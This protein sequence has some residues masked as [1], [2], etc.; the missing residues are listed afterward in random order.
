MATGYECGKRK[1]AAMSGIGYYYMHCYY[2]DLAHTISHT[3]LF[4]KK[5]PMHEL[6]VLFLPPTLI[7]STGINCTL[8][9]LA[10]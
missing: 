9:V 5:N 2:S 7:C 1:I 10:T 6:I 8:N 3:I 4:F